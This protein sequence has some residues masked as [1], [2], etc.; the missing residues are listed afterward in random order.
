ML[1]LSCSEKIEFRNIENV[2]KLEKGDNIIEVVN[3]MEGMPDE[4]VIPDSTY[5]N[6]SKINGL[7]TFIYDTPKLSSSPIYIYFKDCEVL[8]IFYD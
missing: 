6:Q 2:S 3:K 4:I 8:S 1:F 7:M 5:L